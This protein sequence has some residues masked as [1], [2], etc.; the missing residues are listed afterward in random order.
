MLR[1]TPY[2]IGPNVWVLQQRP[3]PLYLEPVRAHYAARNDK[4]NIKRT[5]EVIPM[6][7]RT[8]KLEDGIGR[9]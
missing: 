6:P 3:R 4:S 8:R 2:R 9:F 7:L 5:A 1:Q